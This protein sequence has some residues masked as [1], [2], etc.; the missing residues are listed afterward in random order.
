M[1]KL[2]YKHRFITLL[3]CIISYLCAYG[4][5]I[6]SEMA[7]KYAEEGNYEKAIELQVKAVAMA[8]KQYGK[9]NDYYGYS[10]F[11]LAEY[12][13]NNGNYKNAIEILEKG[14]RI[15]EKIY[16][17]EHP[18][19]AISLNNLAS[20]N[21][22]LGNYSEAIRFG[23]Q[24]LEILEKIL[25]KEHPGYATILSNLA[26][27]NA[28]L[29]NYDEAIRLDTQAL[30][31]LEKALGKEHPGYATSLNNLASYNADL[32][33]Y[34]EAIRLGTQVLE[35]QEKILGKEHPGYV[36]SLSNLAIYNS[37][38]GNYS[39]AIRLGT[40]A[41][42]IT[43]KALG[44][45]HSYYAISLNNLALSNTML[46]N[47]SEAI[48]LGTQALEIQE[49]IL[50]KEHP[51]YATSLSNL[52]GYNTNLGNYSE[53]IRLDTKA[54]EILEKILGK[55]HPDYATSLNILAL[56][57]TA[58]GNYDEAIR[59]GTQALEIRE[60][61]LGKEHPDY[62]NT[63][64]SLVLIHE[65]TN[66]TLN[67]IERINE[68]IP[69]RIKYVKSLF[70]TLPSTERKLFWG[71][72][73][74]FFKYL[75]EITSKFLDCYLIEL[76]YDGLLISKG[77]LL[78]SEIEFDKFLS[79]TGDE[80]LLEKYNEIKNI[81]L[82]LNK[83]YEKPIA[84]R[85]VDTDSLERRANELERQLMQESAEFGDYTRNLTMTW[86]GV[87]DSLK[88]K[89]AAIEFVSFPQN[90][91]STMYMAYILRP[92]MESPTMVKLF[93]E[94]DLTNLIDQDDKA[95]IYSD[96]A[97]SELIWGK[98]R[99]H[100]EGVENVYFAPDGILHQIAIEYFPDVDG[101]GLISDRYNLHRL[102][103]TREIA[104][105]RHN[106]PTK[107]A[108]IYGG[109]KYDTDVATMETESRKYEHPKSRGLNP[110]YNLGDSLALRGS[111][112][113]LD[114][115]LTEAEN[116]SGMMKEKN[117]NSTFL[118]GNDATEES[119][120]SLSGQANGIIHIST[121]GFY[122][123]ES[124]AERKAGLNDRLMFMSQLGD[125][126]RRNV[127]DK[128]L[129]RT[130]LFMA[131]AKNALGGIELPEDVDD[132]LLTAQEIANLDLRGLDL[133][134]LSA[135]Q[136]GMGDI[137]DD[138]VFGLQRGFKKAGANSIL[139]SLW[140][141]SDEATQILMTEFYRNY[142]SGKSKQESLGLAQQYLRNYTDGEEDYSAPE[143]WAAFILLDALN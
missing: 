113:Y 112:E 64:F 53:A 52:A 55:E 31:I 131:G 136:T 140:D 79:E 12:Y 133:V 73:S 95:S 124:E 69:F 121:H 108:V 30:E 88:G 103:S 47:Y 107:E 132:G 83:L 35:I 94:K 19:Y 92:E 137:S 97:A 117:Y 32:G 130:G 114:G 109:I 128:A 102:S 63:I 129:T 89:D 75:Q 80:A 7:E 36:T 143:Y 48:R 41:L 43:E 38:V 61:A 126:A 123:T 122:W 21:S 116:I 40:Q 70:T 13:A 106:V 134:V 72:E 2:F 3:F 51:G 46:G 110:Y 8:E 111:L 34:T 14:L 135:C 50:G 71:N 44:K 24:A 62:A 104:L 57:N 138:G 67:V 98:L 18:D 42:E 77:I 15:T 4:Q 5:S 65:A 141:V 28:D 23:T 68:I 93:E 25:G 101:Q 127:E 17:K 87:R 118:S 115:S 56:S 33:N 142:L 49:K 78:N 27:C 6:Y 91:D 26:Q 120:K 81:R 100:L 37:D 90:N 76:A 139:M 82:Q 119:F 86:E 22:E 105:N 66:D 96:K 11:I 85:Y 20:Y 74:Y 39:E 9:E 16:G 10:L 58:L 45:E 59:L 84:E 29:G 99:P 1:N 125:N 54:L 60:K